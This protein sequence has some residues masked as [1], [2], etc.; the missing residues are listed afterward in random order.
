MTTEAALKAWETRRLNGWRH[1]NAHDVVGEARKPA[2]AEAQKQVAKKQVAKTEAQKRVALLSE[3][4]KKAWA[5]RRSN[6][7]AAAAALSARAKKAALTR[8]RN[9]A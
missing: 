5:T 1:P 7:L 9:A 4:A 6:A 3:R 8:K 2:K